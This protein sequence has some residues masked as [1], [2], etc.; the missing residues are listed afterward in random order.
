M[1]ISHIKPVVILVLRRIE[2]LIV[3]LNEF[4]DLIEV[5]RIKMVALN[6]KVPFDRSGKELHFVGIGLGT[7]VRIG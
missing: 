5:V 3:I 4:V 6:A 7:F 1:L 2:I